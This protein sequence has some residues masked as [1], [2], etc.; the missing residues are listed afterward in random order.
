MIGRESISRYFVERYE[1]WNFTRITPWGRKIRYAQ[2]TSL[3]LST[4]YH[5]YVFVCVSR[6]LYARSRYHLLCTYILSSVVY[7]YTYI[8]IAIKLICYFDV[9]INDDGNSSYLV[10]AG[11]H[12][13]LF[14]ANETGANFDKQDLR[15]NCRR[16]L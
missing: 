5:F 8:Y 4:K 2:I 12:S 1:W 7:I 6:N 10:R 13:L 14:S 11:Y 15:K 9:F 3:S 16:D